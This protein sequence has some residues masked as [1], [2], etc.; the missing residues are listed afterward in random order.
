MNLRSKSTVG[1][2]LNQ[3]IPCDEFYGERTFSVNSLEQLTSLFTLH[4]FLYP[5]YVKS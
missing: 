2:K 1:V 3:P 5:F 4:S